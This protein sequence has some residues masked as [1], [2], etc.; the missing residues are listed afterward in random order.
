M[1]TEFI[2]PLRIHIEDTDFTGT[3]YHANYLNFFERARSEWVMKL[4]MGIEWQKQHH[5][6][7]LVH[8]MTISFL[9]PATVHEAVEVVSTIK[10]KR[11]ASIIFDQRLR[12]SADP[13]KLFCK[14]EIIVACVDQHLRPC[15]IPPN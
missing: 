4:G 14:A 6:T 8:S 9:K 13:A 11:K 10:E 15:A 1:S 12:S 7:F 2:Y 3:V 5:I